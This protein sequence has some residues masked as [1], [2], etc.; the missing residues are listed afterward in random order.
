MRIDSAVLKDEMRYEV[1]HLREKAALWERGELRC[2]NEQYIRVLISLYENAKTDVFATTIPEYMQT[3]NS[4]LG[5]RFLEAHGRSR[6]NVVRLF[7]FDKLTDIKEEDLRV[8]RKHANQ[9]RIEVRVYIETEDPVFKFPTDISRD[10]TVVDRGETIGISVS[11]GS[12]DLEAQ[13]YFR[14]QNRI[15]RFAQIER[16]LRAGSRSLS[17]IETRWREQANT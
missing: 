10:F 4:P 16:S 12:D 6:A 15:A 1:D 3:W 9:G 13:W 5:D 2:S 7:I 17:E 14:D 8:M 11:Y